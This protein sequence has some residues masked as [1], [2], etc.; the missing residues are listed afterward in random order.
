MTAL[1][2]A[3]ELTVVMLPLP[4]SAIG[5]LADLEEGQIALSGFV[6]QRDAGLHVRR[7]QLE[8]ATDF[9]SFVN[10][11]VASGL[12]FRALDYAQLVSLLYDEPPGRA[13]DGEDEVYL[14]ADITAFRPERQ[15]LYKALA[16]EGDQAVYLFEPLYS[17]ADAEQATTEQETTAHQVGSGHGQ[18]CSEQRIYLDIDEFI[19]SAWRQGVRF[20]LDI[21]AVCEGIELDRPERRVVARSRPCVPGKNA[22][23]CEQAPGLHRNNAPRRVVGDRVDLRQFETRYPQVAAGIRLVMKTARTLGQDGRDISGEALPAPLPK[24]FDLQELAG[25]GTCVSREKDGEYLLASVCGFLNIDR[26][27]NQFSVADRIVSHE[28]VSART[29]GD[30]LL[31]GDE[32]EQHGEIQEKRIVQCRSITAYADV[33][34]K[35]ISSGGLVRL[36]RNL[37]G[38][39]ASNAGGDIMIDGIASGSTL[40]AQ[41]GCIN[42]QR[43][44]HCLIIGQQVIIGHATSCDIVADELKLDISEACALA[45]KNI[46]VG[47]ARSRR[48]VDSVL[49]LR[50]PDLSSQD[51]Q[52]AVLQTKRAALEAALAD[53]RAGMDALRGDQGLARYLLLGGKLRRHEVS[54][55]P[56]QHLAWRRLSVLV[57]PA[58]RTLSQ[59]ADLVKEQDA[60]LNALR[61]QIADLLAAR[62]QSCSGLACSVDRID[63]ETRVAAL[64][65]RLADTPLSELPGKDLKVR[66]RRS[67]A[68]TK[69]LFTGST[70]TFSWTYRP[71]LT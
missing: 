13:E 16:I 59:L 63:G 56:E 60:G 57:A 28:G 67:D 11:V 58:L 37:V 35:I 68:A 33:F 17:E 22:E 31:T 54:L 41:H 47:L 2:T 27:S 7:S 10:R 4:K 20:G 43:A 38:G 8:A 3:P 30:L 45:G 71:P 36:K 14:A 32:Y 21:A 44:D 62:E 61:A 69:L 53:H 50:L 46:H 48:E 65:L 64:L 42:V 5:N 39:S 9:P 19:V 15:V 52:I 34:G 40:I 6:V 26:R 12:Y 49:L 66:L 70:G 29:T 1:P 18:A 25:A 55:N 24:D 23:I 51:A